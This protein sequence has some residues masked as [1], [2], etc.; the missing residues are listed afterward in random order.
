MK[1][2]ELKAILKPLIKECIKEVMF[3]DGILSGIVSE[4]ATGMGRVQIVEAGPPKAQRQPEPRSEDFGAMRQKSLQEQKQK[5]DTHR[6]KLLDAVG[7]DSY[8]GVNIFEGTS[9]L[10]SSGP[11]PGS[12]PAPRGALAGVDPRDSGVDISNLF[13]HVGRNWQAH[14]KAQK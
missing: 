10:K 12:D 5:L 6:K 11:P 2:T 14:L 7:K 3:E 4:V 9:P 1:K 8:N 13:E